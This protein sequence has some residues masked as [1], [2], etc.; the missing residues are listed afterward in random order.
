MPM[1][2]VPTDRIFSI[3]PPQNIDYKT[4]NP[5]ARL[6]TLLQQVEL[7]AEA[8][9]YLGSSIQYLLPFDYLEFYGPADGQWAETD[10]RKEDN[11]EDF[12]KQN[13]H[14]FRCT[15]TWIARGWA[16]TA[17]D[18]DPNSIAWTGPFLFLSYRGGP[19]SKLS[20]ASGHKLG[21][22]IKVQLNIPNTNTAPV[23]LD[24]PYNVNTD[25]YELEIW[26]YPYG[27]LRDELGPKGQAAMDRGNLI[28]M[29]A[30]VLGLHSD[31]AREGLD[32]RDMRTVA[33]DNLMH[34]ILP[35]TVEITWTDATGAFKDAADSGGPY[36]YQFSMILRGWENFLKVGV[37]ES[38]HGGFGFLH[39]R[40]VLSNYFDF[41]NSNELGRNVEPWMFDANG[42]KPAVEQHEKFLSVEY[43]DVHLLKGECGIGLHH[44]RDNQEIFYL[45][46]G[47]ALMVMGDFYKMPD[48]DRA[49]EIR[50]MA[51]GSFS[52]LKP[53]NL[54]ALYNVTDLDISLLMFGGYD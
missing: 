33:P 29:P 23:T 14:D 30:L 25:R 10:I 31:F 50:T 44:H 3:Q 45:L 36:R 52:L 49:F 41:K 42:N 35:L 27:N 24:V 53:G 12:Q 28:A 16:T 46:N 17:W 19:D 6:I 1:S 8:D 15:D 5:L 37:S 4:N 32:G 22:S 9:S 18:A 48:R 54:H 43:M 20:Q 7:G 39:Y 38:P 40:N 2:L 26:G 13:V 34:P 21:T 47:T 51:G 11:K